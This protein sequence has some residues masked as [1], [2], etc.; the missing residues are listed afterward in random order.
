MTS[1]PPGSHLLL[2]DF[3][4]LA[5][6]GP[7]KPASPH[8]ELRRVLR[9]LR[10]VALATDATHVQICADPDR[11]SPRFA[12][13]PD[14]TRK[15]V[16]LALLHQ[17]GYPVAQDGGSADA[18]LIALA[19]TA[20][21]AGFARVTILSGDADLVAAVLAGTRTALWWFDW[22]RGGYRYFDR[23]ALLRIGD[24]SRRGPQRIV[25]QVVEDGGAAGFMA[26]AKV[27]DRRTSR[28]LIARFG[29]AEAALAQ[30]DQVEPAALRE[31]LRGAGVQIR[32]NGRARHPDRTPTASDRAAQRV[33]MKLFAPARLGHAP[34]ERPSGATPPGA[35]PSHPEG[36]AGWGI[37]EICA[38]GPGPDADAA[39]RKRA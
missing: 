15:A 35:T 13:G 30:L 28:R 24:G 29:S 36:M 18:L 11:P 31:R 37:D 21:A 19:A 3:D 12:G 8:A 4:N 1:T 10:Q 14:E 34:L 39:V 25:H 9:L 5:I 17:L 16:A 32:T 20:E 27:L 22:R 26:F 7:S 2:L 33:A 6:S 38:P 23:E